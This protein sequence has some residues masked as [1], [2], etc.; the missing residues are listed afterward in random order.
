L[1]RWQRVR[2][3]VSMKQHHLSFQ[4]ALI[5]LRLERLHFAVALA[6][7]NLSALRDG[8]WLN[9]REDFLAFLGQSRDPDRTATVSDAGGLVS[10]RWPAPFPE[11]FSERDFQILQYEVRTILQAAAGDNMGGFPASIDVKATLQVQP[12]DGRVSPSG[13]YITSLH[14][15]TRDQ[16]LFLLLDALRHEPPDR[17]LRCPEC[18]ALFVR[19]YTQAYCS[20]RCTNR[21]SVRQWR[22]RQAV[23][24]P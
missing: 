23:S 2:M 22:A 5:A 7:Y 15:S 14:G 10:T 11:D 8:D 9:L 24:T 13:G 4:K 12:Q 6:Q 3:L 16:F 20:R 18:H 17:I 21:A 19:S 1:T